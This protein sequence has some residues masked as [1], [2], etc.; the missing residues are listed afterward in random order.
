[1]EY[2]EFKGICLYEKNPD[3]VPDVSDCIE[4]RGDHD[5]LL[6]SYYDAERVI[7]ALRHGKRIIEKKYRIKKILKEKLR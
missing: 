7:K 4:L 2:Y 6:I 3:N 1:M 5:N